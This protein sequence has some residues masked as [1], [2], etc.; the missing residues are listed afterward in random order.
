MSLQ[1]FLIPLLTF[2]I[3]FILLLIIYSNRMSSPMSTRSMTRRRQS[4]RLMKNCI[5]TNQRK[6]RKDPVLRQK[7]YKLSVKVGGLIAANNK[8]IPQ[9]ISLTVP[10]H[11]SPLTSAKNAAATLANIA[12][13]LSET[14]AMSGSKNEKKEITHSRRSKTYQEEPK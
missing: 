6:K 7:D 12:S 8:S 14:T 10:V 2:P 9:E 1:F 5:G 11:E 13:Q 3:W 4:P